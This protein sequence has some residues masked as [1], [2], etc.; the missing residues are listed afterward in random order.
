[1]YEVPQ[2]HQLES[3][4]WDSK[5]G[6]SDPEAL[7]PYNPAIHSQG[8]YTQTL[9]QSLNNLVMLAYQKKYLSFKWK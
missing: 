9:I 3:S 2:D 7:P 5:P 6:L 4:S 1:M 8:H